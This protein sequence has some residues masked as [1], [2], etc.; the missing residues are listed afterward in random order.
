MF[1]RVKD[2][3]SCHKPVVQHKKDWEWDIVVLMQGD[4]RQKWIGSGYSKPSRGIEKNIPCR[5]LVDLRAVR[6]AAKMFFFIACSLQRTKEE[7]F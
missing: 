1:Q 5:D 2:V 7:N 4:T 3:M 6:E